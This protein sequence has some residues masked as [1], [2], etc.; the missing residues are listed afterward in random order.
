MTRNEMIHRI[1]EYFVLDTP[2]KDDDGNYIID[3]GDWITGG[4]VLGNDKEWRW[5]TWKRLI[6]DVLCGMFDDDDG[7]K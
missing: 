1:V 5:D 2:Q 4:T 7:H 3:D 6:D